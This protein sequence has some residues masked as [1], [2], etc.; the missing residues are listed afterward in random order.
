M[1]QDHS[2]QKR[3]VKRQR[4]KKDN[5]DLRRQELGHWINEPEKRNE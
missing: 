1:N 4:P 5:K 2:S 3:T